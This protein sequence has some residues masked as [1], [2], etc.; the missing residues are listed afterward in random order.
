MPPTCYLFNGTRF[1]FHLASREFP[2]TLYNSQW[3]CSV[4]VR[5]DSL[6]KYVRVVARSGGY[7]FTLCDPVTFTFD[8]LTSK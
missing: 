3:R 7:A 5:L 4:A 2:A 1:H 6:R 8:L